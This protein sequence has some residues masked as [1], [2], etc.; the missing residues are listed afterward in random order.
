MR[1][2]SLWKLNVFIK[3][4]TQL[5]FLDPN[6]LLIYQIF[7]YMF[8]VASMF[9][10]AHSLMMDGKS[11][12]E[13]VKT[14]LVSRSMMSGISM[15]NIGCLQAIATF[16][17]FKEHNS[18]CISCWYGYYYTAC[19]PLLRACLIGQLPFHNPKHCSGGG[20][21]KYTTTRFFQLKYVCDRRCWSIF[22]A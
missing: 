10:Q 15:D 12:R 17:F 1:E 9:M 8:L 22:M 13:V 7:C 19:E 20:E 5:Q 16:S 3:E 14:L 4:A 6:P 21:R 18:H 11:V 2:T